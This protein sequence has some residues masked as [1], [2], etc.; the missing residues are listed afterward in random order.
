MTDLTQLMTEAD[1][2]TTPV[3]RTTP[4]LRA[5]RQ[6]LEE[7]ALVYARMKTFNV[8]IHE[9]G[10]VIRVSRVDAEPR[11]E[12]MLKAIGDAAVDL[13]LEMS[14]SMPK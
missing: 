3:E 5:A 9:N 1:K 4:Q 11:A 8:F 7:R 6:V 10:S 2:R 13:L 14:L 12:Q